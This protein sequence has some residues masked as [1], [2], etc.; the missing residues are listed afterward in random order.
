[1]PDLP[2][3][4]RATGSLLI[5]GIG[6]E[7]GTDVDEVLALAD[8]ALAQCGHADARP[9][10]VVSLDS[11][12]GEPAI[13]AVAERFGVPF[14][15]FDAAT[16]EAETPRLANPSEAVFRHTGCHGVAEA[17]AL[18]A[19]GTNG[20]L[21]VAKLKSERATVAIAESFQGEGGGTSDFDSCPVAP[22]AT[23]GHACGVAG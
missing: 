4:C 13:Q 22:A 5:L 1:M 12:K 23:A 8:I 17:A 3:P 9:H 18:A 7:R 11:R 2:D 10:L 15:C 20:R 21:V 14:T 6:C 16:L 19:A